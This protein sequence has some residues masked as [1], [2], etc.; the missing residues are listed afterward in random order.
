MGNWHGEQHAGT[1]ADP[2]QIVASQQ[3][4]DPETGGL[5]LPN[6]VIATCNKFNA[7]VKIIAGPL[8]PRRDPSSYCL[9]I[10]QSELDAVEFDMCSK[11]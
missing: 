10:N 2:K 9:S 3:C 11:F 7:S 1:R 4:G 8:V 6:Y 5:V